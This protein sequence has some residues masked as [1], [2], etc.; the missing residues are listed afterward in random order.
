MTKH[1]FGQ[2]FYQI[3]VLC[4]IIFFGDRFI[5]EDLPD[6]KDVNGN[7]IIYNNG[8]GYIRSGRINMPFSLQSDYHPLEI[9][10]LSTSTD[11][12]ILLF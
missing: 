3:T 1:I 11:W 7:S 8:T 6:L 2:S 10:N 5:P 4:I 9:V 12:L